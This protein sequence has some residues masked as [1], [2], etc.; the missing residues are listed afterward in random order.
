[1][2]WLAGLILAMCLRQRFQGPLPGHLTRCRLRLLDRLH[3]G[4]RLK[5]SALATRRLELLMRWWRALAPYRGEVA[6]LC[7]GVSLWSGVVVLWQAW[8][9]LYLKY[10]SWVQLV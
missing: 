2:G 10:S 5:K 7:A 1:M 9:A 8:A 4:L 3:D 6:G